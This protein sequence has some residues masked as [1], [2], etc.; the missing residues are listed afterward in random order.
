MA[1]TPGSTSATSYLRQGSSP[2]VS[3]LFGSPAT[4]RNTPGHGLRSNI[5]I[6]HHY[7]I[8]RTGHASDALS[9]GQ[10]VFIHKESM[11]VR[12][13]TKLTTVLN[14]PAL[15]YHLCKATQRY[16]TLA[17]VLDKWCPQGIIVHE[18]GSAT[19]ENKQ[20]RIVN[21][22]V[23]GWANTYNLWGSVSDGD[24]L[25]LTVRRVT[26]RE[27]TRF[28]LS[29]SMTYQV[30][31]AVDVWQIVPETTPSFE[32]DECSIRIGRVF[33]SPRMTQQGITHATHRVGVD[34]KAMKQ[35]APQF[36]VLFNVSRPR[37]LV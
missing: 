8:Q 11:P 4:V 12:Y 21:C 34:I 26:L 5:A 7:L 9:E 24:E 10:L 32:Q 37:L 20:C 3:S 1:L 23:G 2:G 18:V 30:P 27:G 6:N 36:E 22:T 28:V 35:N 14:V 31:T 29:H 13:A 19:S 33:R 16:P 25:Y 17:S 15:N